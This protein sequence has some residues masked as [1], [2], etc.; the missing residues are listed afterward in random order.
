MSSHLITNDYTYEEMNGL[1]VCVYAR[2][3]IV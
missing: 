2:V 1:H 3:Y